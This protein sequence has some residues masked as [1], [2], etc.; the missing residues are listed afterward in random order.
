[1]YIN[2]NVEPWGTTNYRRERIN[3]GVTGKAGGDIKRVW[4]PRK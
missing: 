3:K 1:M 4:S 2:I